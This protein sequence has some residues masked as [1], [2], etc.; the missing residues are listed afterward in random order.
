MP[1]DVIQD[2]EGLDVKDQQDAVTAEPK[3]A[4]EDAK[5]PDSQDDDT[6]IAR[7]MK[8][9]RDANAEALEFRYR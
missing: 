6:D 5:K 4:S 7:A 2:D 3:P 1:E 9:K 8:L